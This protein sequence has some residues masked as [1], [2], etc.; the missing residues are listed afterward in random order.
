MVFGIARQ[1]TRYSKRVGLCPAGVED[2]N[3]LSTNKL[4][5][6]EW[7]GV[8]KF[9]ELE[10]STCVTISLANVPKMV[11][12]LGRSGSDSRRATKNRQTIKPS[13]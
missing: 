4:L 7:I 8:E 3:D 6:A 5:A 9:D 1:V 11:G 2:I 10:C 13:C 12:G